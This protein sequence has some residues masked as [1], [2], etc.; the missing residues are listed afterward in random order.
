MLRTGALSFNGTKVTDYSY[1]WSKEIRL[2]L[3]AYTGEKE[4]DAL[5]QFYDEEL[6]TVRECLNFLKEDP[7]G[8]DDDGAKN[9]GTREAIVE[10][11][12]LL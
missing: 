11:G 5:S 1:S 6:D 10:S 8:N 3:E 4:E 2:L 12:L 9:R 7:D